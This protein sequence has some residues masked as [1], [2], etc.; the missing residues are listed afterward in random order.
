M[1]E[2]KIKKPKRHVRRKLKFAVMTEHSA[3]PDRRLA[4]RRPME[5]PVWVEKQPRNPGHPSLVRARTRDVSHKGAFLW[6]P[7]VLC[8]GQR[9]RL[10]MDVGPELGQNLGLNIR[11]EAQVVRVEP[12]NPPER[13]A[14]MAVRILS[15]ST[16][17]PV[18]P[19]GS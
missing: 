1:Q 3:A 9:L 13:Q 10:E 7:P 18:P 6:A 4:L 17:R 5:M 16:P 14:G 15:F 12:A 2:G 11:C 8:A 19:P